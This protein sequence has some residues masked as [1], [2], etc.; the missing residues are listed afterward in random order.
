M[1]LA[2]DRGG[3]SNHVD[4]LIGAVPAS[5]GRWRAASSSALAPMSTKRPIR[6]SQKS[7][8]EPDD[9]H[10]QPQVPASRRPQWSPPDC[11]DVEPM[12]REAPFRHPWGERV[13]D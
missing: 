8:E 13:G 9:D 5:L 7:S 3:S 4:E 10:G 6:I 12:R 2:T 11:F 1:T